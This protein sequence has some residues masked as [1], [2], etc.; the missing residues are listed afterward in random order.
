MKTAPLLCDMAGLA[1]E[2][3]VG[4]VVI[5]YFKEHCDCCCC[6]L[7]VVSQMKGEDGKEWGRTHSGTRVTEDLC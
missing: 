4:Y 5:T 2:I 1:A 3:P 6:C 7:T